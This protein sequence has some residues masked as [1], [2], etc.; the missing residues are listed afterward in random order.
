[1]VVGVVV[2][3]EGV[4]VGV[5]VCDVLG[6]VVGVLVGVVVGEVVGV[7]PCPLMLMY[8]LPSISIH[9]AVVVP[10]EPLAVA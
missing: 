10:L 8:Q 6:T 4:V 1:M 2:T 3:G 5:V 7:L 9:G